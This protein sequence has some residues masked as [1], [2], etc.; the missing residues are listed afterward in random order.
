MLADPSGNAIH[1]LVGEILE[2]ENVC[3]FAGPIDRYGHDKANGGRYHEYGNCKLHLSPAIYPAK[4]LAK[5]DHC[6][7]K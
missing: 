1:G 7:M 6:A 3:L 5:P 2:P 4:G